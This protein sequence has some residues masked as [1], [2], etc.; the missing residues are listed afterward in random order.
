MPVASP[1]IEVAAW[2]AECQRGA[3]FTGAAISTESG[4]PDF[5][6]PGDPTPL[7]GIA[8]FV[9]HEPIGQTLAAIENELQRAT[10]QKEERE[11]R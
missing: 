11:P 8:D 4:I 9:I 5:R 7:D 1:I 3:A 6:S 2:L 10:S